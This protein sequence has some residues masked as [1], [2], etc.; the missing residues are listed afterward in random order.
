MTTKSTSS[1]TG[2]ALNL[3]VIC[4]RNNLFG[5]EF[6]RHQADKHGINRIDKMLIPK[7]TKDNKPYVRKLV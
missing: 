3:V 5:P 6:P 1:M 4:G 7:Y 2:N